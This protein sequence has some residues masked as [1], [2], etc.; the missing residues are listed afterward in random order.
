MV[1]ANVPRIHAFCLQSHAFGSPHCTWLLLGC[2]TPCWPF[3]YLG[4]GL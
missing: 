4:W 2:P 1:L 3:V